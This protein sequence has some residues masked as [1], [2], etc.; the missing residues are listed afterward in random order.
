MTSSSSL[1]PSPECRLSRPRSKMSVA[2][3][4]QAGYPAGALGN[5]SLFATRKPLAATLH[6][7][8]ELREVHLERVEDV[9]RV[10]LGAEP[11]LA[12]TR[13]RVLD[14]LL[15]LA[16]RLP[17]DFLFADQP[18][19][20]LARL[21][22]DPLSLALRLGEHL[23]TLL[24]DPARLLDLLR[25][26]GTHLIEDVVDLLFVDAHGVRERHLLGVVNCV[27]E[28]VDEDEDVHGHLVFVSAEALPSSAQRQGPG[29]AGSD[30]RR[31]WQVPSLRRSS[32]S[33]SSG[34]T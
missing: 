31:T 11:D 18:R 13:T 6:G 34:K 19:L 16:L 20:L 32:G 22:D 15:G 8:D 26:R 25:D 1:R 30:R 9:V 28:F 10:I 21:A 12:L 24:D 2:P 14:D 17:D 33:R 3:A 7:G 5:L 29:R 23:L 4:I 27:V